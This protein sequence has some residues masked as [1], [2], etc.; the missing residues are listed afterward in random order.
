MSGQPPPPGGPPSR[1]NSMQGPPSAGL[2]GSQA[3]AQPAGSNTAPGT[4]GATQ[5]NL[6]QIAAIVFTV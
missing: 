4:G 5:Q 3:I 6:N 2:P 1:S